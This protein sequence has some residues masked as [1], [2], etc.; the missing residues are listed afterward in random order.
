MKK[1]HVARAPIS[2]LLTQLPSVDKLLQVTEVKSFIDNF[3]RDEVLR[4]VR[5]T[6]QATREEIQKRVY[7]IA[8]MRLSWSEILS[9][10][11]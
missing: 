2:E 5:Q 3:G 10:S 7:P 8:L 4:A 1:E 11:W 6:L 9:A